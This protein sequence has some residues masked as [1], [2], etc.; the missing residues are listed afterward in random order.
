MTSTALAAAASSLTT[1]G[2]AFAA[3]LNAETGGLAA[4][5]DLACLAREDRDLTL[6]LDLPRRRV[7]DRRER[8]VAT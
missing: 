1:S 8:G 4:A 5:F 7:L 2:A 3:R 6:E